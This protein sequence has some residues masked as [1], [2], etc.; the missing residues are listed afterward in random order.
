MGEVPVV[1]SLWLVEPG[2]NVVEGD[3]VLEVLCEAAT[4]DLAAPVTGRLREFLVDEGERLEVGQR[5]AV[6]VAEAV[7]ED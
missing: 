6:F 2:E 1:A 5:L 4:V 7:S 3:R